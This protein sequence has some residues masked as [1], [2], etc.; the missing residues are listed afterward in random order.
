MSRLVG[1]TVVV[2]TENLKVRGRITAPEE[3]PPFYLPTELPNVPITVEIT[4]VLNSLLNY[5][6]EE[7]DMLRVPAFQIEGNLFDD[8]LT[9]STEVNHEPHFSDTEHHTH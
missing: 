2:V 9:D 6:V 5:P 8:I 4:E 1:R 7:G 3:I